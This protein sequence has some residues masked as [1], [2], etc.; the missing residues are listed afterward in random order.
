MSVRIAGFVSA[1]ALATAAGTVGTS[2]QQDVTA[3]ARAIHD[4]VIA[5]DTHNDIDPQN[6]TAECNYTMRLT[7]QVN[8]PK[9]KDGGL[10]ASFFIAYVGQQDPRNV[11]D[12]L[13]PAG[14]ERAYRAAVAKFDAVHRLTEQI[15]PK[16]IELALTAADVTRIARS[17]KKVAV[18][19]IENGYPVG[20]DIKRV[21]EFYDRGGRYMSLAHNGHNQLADSHTGE[22]TGEWKW[23]GVSPLGKQVIQEMN[24][25]GMMIDISHPSRAAIH[26]MIGLSKAPVIASHSSIRKVGDVSRNVDDDTMMAIKTNGGVVQLNALSGFIKPDPRE[27][28]PAINSLRAEFGLGGGRGGG[29]GGAGRGSAAPAA[30]RCPVE[31][32]PAPAAQAGRGGRG[33]TQGAETLPPDRRAEFERRLAQIDRQWPPSGRA[34]VKDFVDHMDYAVKIMGIDHVGIASDF[35]GGGGIDG[36]NSAAETFNV[37]L[38]MVRRGYTEE[39]IAKVWSGN[40]LRVWS[41]VEQVAKQI[42]S[43]S[44]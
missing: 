43:G 36:W 17:G 4:R 28:G 15:A 44:R 6:F 13:E 10:D 2:A 19:G 27:R 30:Y 42:Q 37:T 26:Q 16:E 41:Q 14:F 11:S 24:R 25:L 9:M 7:T 29:G 1:A 40:L 31:T 20:T 3:R 23:G 21:K 5:L 12:A 39:Q 38:E 8:L 22:A 35:D 33:A 34:T 32:T 18:I